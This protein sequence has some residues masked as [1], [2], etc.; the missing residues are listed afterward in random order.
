VSYQKTSNREGCKSAND[1]IQMLT[2]VRSNNLE[3]MLN[4]ITI[5]YGTGKCIDFEK[6]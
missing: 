4:D 5:Y 6:G 3:A 2:H 1:L